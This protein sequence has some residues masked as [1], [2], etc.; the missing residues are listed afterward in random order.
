MPVFATSVSAR[1]LPDFLLF[2]FA[3][4]ACFEAL[5]DFAAARLPPPWPLACVLGVSDL[6]RADLDISLLAW[7]D[8][9]V[10]PLARVDLDVSPLARVDAESAFT[11]FLVLAEGLWEGVSRLEA[12]GVG[13]LLGVDMMGSLG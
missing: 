1:L 7:V 11:D 3:E 10:S 8:L 2:F 9:D 4:P 12:P 13:F 5:S 6:V